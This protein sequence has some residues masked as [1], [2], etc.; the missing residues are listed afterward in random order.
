[1]PLPSAL[2]A[3]LLSLA[4]A[5]IAAPASAEA[6]DPPDPGQD[7]RRIS[8]V[9][10][11]GNDI[12]HPQ[13][14]R[15]G[16]DGQRYTSRG[17]T[18]TPEGARFGVVGV[19]GGTAAKANPCLPAQLAWAGS[20]SGLPNQPALQ[21]YVN[22]AN[23]GGVLDSEELTTWPVRTAA[24]NP[25]NAVGGL[26]EPCS[27]GGSGTN[28]LA[29]SWEYGWGRADW[30]AELA[31]EA[32]AVADVAL[33]LATTRVWL[34]VE[35]ANTWQ[36]AAQGRTLNAAALEGMVARFAELG[37]TVG[38]YSTSLQWGLIV[39][40]QE[41]SSGGLAGLDSWIAGA[42]DLRAAVAFCE[43]RAALTPGGVVT[44]TQFVE[45]GLDHNYSCADSH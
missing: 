30:G 33:D 41:G 22:T 1:M 2:S 27:A 24:H 37:T 11:V 38:L 8:V 5:W 16:W 32:A 4:A 31:L 9:S 17:A 23:P 3:V 14:T 44:L 42:G 19:N 15:S 28:S 20:L 43:A 29:C 45:D 40:A 36:R 35:T 21:L 39:G 12:S 6:G 34:D 10:P 13:C 26:P 7:S 25:Y 18:R